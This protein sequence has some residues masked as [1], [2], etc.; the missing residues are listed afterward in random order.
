MFDQYGNPVEPEFGGAGGGGATDFSVIRRA[1]KMGAS[2]GGTGQTHHCLAVV[3]ANDSD[4]TAD[5]RRAGWLEVHAEQ[6]ELQG[7][8]V[9][10]VNPRVWNSMNMGEKAQKEKLFR[11]RIEALT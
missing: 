1:A 2:G 4:F 3:V 11:E 9:L 8:D 10:V 7:Y 5:G 6:L